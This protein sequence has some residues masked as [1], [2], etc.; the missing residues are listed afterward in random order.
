M[1]RRR[2][3]SRAHSVNITTNNNHNLPRAWGIFALALVAI[4]A[5]QLYSLRYSPT[6]WQDEVQ[7]LDFGRTLWRGEDRSH[8]MSWLD[9]GRPYACINYIGC[10]IQELACRLAADGPAGPRVS[11]L[12]AACLAAA[13]A[14]GW[15]LQS[16]VRPWVASCCALTFLLM[17]I[18]VLSYRGGR[19]DS[20]AIAFMMLALWTAAKARAALTRQGDAA[21]A[22]LGVA[23]AWYAMCGICLGLAG[24]VWVSAIV[25]VPL[26]L[27]ELLR[28]QRGSAVFM[29]RAL[30][31]AAVSGV[32]AVIF[33]AASLLA[34]WPLL[35]EMLQD[36]EL[37]SR[38]VV[39][40][41]TAV[42]TVLRT[43]RAFLMNPLLPVLGLA[44][45][46]LARKWWL[47][48]AL[49]GGLALVVWT[50]EGYT[51]R[52]VYLVPYF[53]AGLAFGAEAAL[54]RWQTRRVF[55]VVAAALL[56][57]LL[58]SAAVTLGGRTLSVYAGSAGRDPGVILDMAREKIGAGPHKVYL[59]TWDFGYAA[60]KLGWKFS[61]RFKWENLK[62]PAFLAQL[63]S[64]DH[65]ITASSNSSITPEAMAELGFTKWQIG[66]SP[67]EAGDAPR[68]LG[69]ARYRDYLF[70][71]RPEN[72]KP[73]R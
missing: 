25:L 47:L 35:P 56:A 34:V 1:L 55:V 16:G 65:V 46:I 60:R 43:A 58:L 17:P 22:P 49:V 19:V 29:P 5:V 20:S 42:R 4:A 11:A 10:L 52:S 39:T 38:H 33:I 51:H 6:I 57:C 24:M 50:S 32:F 13:A 63:E 41:E 36:L 14:F 45:M 28:R 62:D 59:W 72:G 9:S 23:L 66:R 61:K 53:V 12:L 54:S 71:S 15:L 7:I 37:K 31:G 67:T 68:W 30:A 21:P 69:T 18:F 3:A 64:V 26:V 48:V 27:G 73:V 44:G 2:S 40:F 8:A 70:Y